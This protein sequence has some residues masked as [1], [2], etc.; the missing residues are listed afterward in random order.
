MSQC[1]NEEGCL[2]RVL[3]RRKE[4]DRSRGVREQCHATTGRR[5]VRFC[6]LT[7]GHEGPHQHGTKLWRGDYE[8]PVAAELR[9]K[10]LVV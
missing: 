6:E 4:T 5:S 1:V 10:I 7:T 8:H 9:S 3:A 2:R